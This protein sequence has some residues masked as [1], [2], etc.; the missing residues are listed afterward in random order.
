[1]A[2]RF[3]TTYE[4][5]F[6]ASSL[7][8]V[9]S[10]SGKL[11]HNMGKKEGMTNVGD[12]RDEIL[13]VDKV[14][15][16]SELNR[17]IDLYDKLDALV[18]FKLVNAAYNKVLSD[19]NQKKLIFYHIHNPDTHAQLNFVRLAP[20]AKWIV[21]VREPLQ[22]LESWIRKRFRKNEHSDCSVSIT[23]ML[24]ELDN[25]IY[26]KQASIGLR[27]EDLKENPR[28]V[29]PALC[30]WMGIEEADSLYEMTAQGKKWWGDP[31]SID[32][33][34]DGMDPFGKTSIHRS[35]GSIFS[36]SDQ[37][38]LRTL[39]YPFSARFGYIEENQTQFKKDLKT[40]R[41]MLD[42]MFD[43]EKTI[44]ERTNTDPEKFMKS[45]SYFYLRSGLIERWETLK[46]YGTYPNMISPLKINWGY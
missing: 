25:I 36:E 39:F 2:D 21:M 44:V 20:E 10:K 18:F 6:D 43:F 17:L 5:L 46:K 33:A 27:L 7:Q 35:V 26:H 14:L 3:R 45:G 22:S 30:N 23:T 24:F 11:L 8:P 41:P 34:K 1:M 13:S 12:Q 31:T 9:S 37:F 4:V 40:I 32:Y 19:L 29:L 28:K 15:F 16:C 42:Q 38:I